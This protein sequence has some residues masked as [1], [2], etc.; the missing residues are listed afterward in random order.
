MIHPVFPVGLIV[1]PTDILAGLGAADRPLLSACIALFEDST[2]ARRL[3]QL[4]G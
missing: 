2:L 3:S 4:Y 1:Q